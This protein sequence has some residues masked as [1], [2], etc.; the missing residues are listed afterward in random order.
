MLRNFDNLNM[1]ST[2]AP[3]R[4][5]QHQALWSG[6]KHRRPSFGPSCLPNPSVP[7]LL[8]GL[9]SSPPPSLGRIPL[10]HCAQQRRRKMKGQGR[11]KHDEVRHA[12]RKASAS[13]GREGVPSSSPF[14]LRLILNINLNVKRPPANHS[15]FRGRN[16]AFATLVH[17][18]WYADR[19]SPEEGHS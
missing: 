18:P 15:V 10:V 16:H 3:G 8:S 5:E 4:Q 17:F 2:F 13:A 11:K 19:T 6:E 7:K 1:E 9:R 12:T 14:E